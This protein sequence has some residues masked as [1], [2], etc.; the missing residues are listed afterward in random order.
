MMDLICTVCPR[1]CHIKVDG[2][3]VSGNACP[4]GRTFGVSESTNPV[5]VL[6]A[7]VSIDSENICRLP[8]K[9]SAAIPKGMM[10]SCMAEIKKIRATA[11]IS[12]GDILV[13]NLLSTGADLIA[14]R[15]VPK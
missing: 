7:T 4:R 11:P 13:K 14:T 8:C 1:G 2:E 3:N 12:A 9:T 5:R 6:T 10:M 15:T